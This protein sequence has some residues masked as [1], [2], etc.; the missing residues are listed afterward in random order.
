MFLEGAAR[1]GPR[2]DSPPQEVLGK[3]GDGTARANVRFVKIMSSS[4]PPSHGGGGQTHSSLLGSGFPGHF[5]IAPFRGAT[6]PTE[7]DSS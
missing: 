3:V 6:T 4:P 2:K 5:L 7:C 1:E